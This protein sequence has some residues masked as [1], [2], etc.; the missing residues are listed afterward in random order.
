MQV[1]INKDIVL[2]A[3]YGGAFLGGGGGGWIEDGIELANIAIAM[4]TPQLVDISELPS[5][6]YIC[7]VSLVG[8]PAASNRCVNPMDY[9]NALKNL[10]KN[11]DMNILGVISNENGAVATINGWIQSA[12]LGI[13]VVDAPSNGRAHPTGVMGSMML[14]KSKTFISYQSAVGGNKDKGKYVETFVK[15]S[16]STTSSIIR[17]TSEHA[18]GLVAVARNPVKANYIKYHGAIGA[19][20]QAIKIGK[21]FLDK[22]NKGA[23]SM[24]EAVTNVAGGEII[25]KGILRDK[26]LKTHKGFDIGEIYI[27]NKKKEYIID[28]WNEYMTLEYNGERLATF[29]DLIMLMNMDTGKPIISA[30]TSVGTRVSIIKVPM[31]KLILGSGMKYRD[32]MVEVEKVLN[33]DICRYNKN[34]FIE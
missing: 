31:D 26:K 10:I 12:I 23:I 27:V 1:I 17:Q 5:D 30:E 6:S 14:N 34:L 28:V 24:I 7:T 20:N 15:G 29:P 18:G 8:A 22:S 4:G 16:V 33:K 21:A 13:P 11:T 3:V 32:N 2:P 9:V 25:D 19:V